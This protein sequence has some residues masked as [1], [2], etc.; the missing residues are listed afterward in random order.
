[1]V[2]VGPNNLSDWQF[3]HAGLAEGPVR[4]VFAMGAYAERL[5]IERSDTSDNRLILDGGGGNWRVV[6][7]GIH[8]GYEGVISHV[9]VRGFEVIGSRDKGIE[10]NAD[11]QILIEDVVVYANTGSPAINLQYSNGSGHASTGFVVRNSH[12][13]NQCGEC[14]YIGA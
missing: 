10:W 6:M 5:Q 12:L 11:D 14:I 7:P 3:I 1:M 4:V 13:Y 8:T 2:E 9:T